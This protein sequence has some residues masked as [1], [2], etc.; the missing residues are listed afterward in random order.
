MKRLAN[1]LAG[2]GILLVVYWVIAKFTGQLSIN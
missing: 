2:I 1:L